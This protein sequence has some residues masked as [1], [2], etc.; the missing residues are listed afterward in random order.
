VSASVKLATVATEVQDTVHEEGRRAAHFARRQSALDVSTDPPQEVRAESILVEAWD[1]ELEL[2][3]VP[4]QIAGFEGLLAMKQ[5]LVRVPEPVLACG[6]L[7]CRRGREGVRVDLDKREVAEREADTAA[8]L[9]LH[10]LDRS[11]RLPRIWVFG[12]A[13]MGAK[14]FADRARRQLLVTGETVRKRTV[15]TRGDL[16]TQE[17]QIARLAA[18]GLSNSE[19]GTRLFISP[20]TVQYH[21]RKVFLKL[22]ISSRTQLGSVLP[23]DTT[24][25]P[26]L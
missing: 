14:A 5:Q 15:E 26:P 3:G 10:A 25:V 11:K 12:F 7:G 6:C 20:R 13:S 19:I 16:T 4:L 23:G 18:N 1:V 21:L 22:G 8:H 17:A 2:D 9:L 24:T